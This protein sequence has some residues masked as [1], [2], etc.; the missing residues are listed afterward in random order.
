MNTSMS[1]TRRRSSGQTWPNY[2]GFV[3]WYFRKKYHSLGQTLRASCTSSL[4]CPRR[5][6]F[7]TH[8]VILPLTNT[9]LLRA[10]PPKFPNSFIPFRSKNFL[11]HFHF[12]FFNNRTYKVLKLL[13]YSTRSQEGGCDLSLW[14]GWFSVGVSSPSPP[15]RPPSPQGSGAGFGPPWVFYFPITHHIWWA[16]PYPPPGEALDWRP[17]QHLIIKN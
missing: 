11:Q 7:P 15:W 2:N 14:A 4:S 17:L 5:L 16:F 1:L 9:A 12:S 8:R 13:A 3:V 10:A 6:H